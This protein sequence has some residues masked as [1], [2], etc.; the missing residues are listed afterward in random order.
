MFTQKAATFLR[1]RV[2]DRDSQSKICSPL[3]AYVSSGT[4]G[5]GNQVGG[6]SLF[7]LPEGIA[8][9]AKAAESLVWSFP[10][11]GFPSITSLHDQQNNLIP[12]LYVQY[13]GVTSC[14]L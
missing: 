6:E 9:L 14:R 4:D 10:V 2:V 7:I 11:E 3:R 12:V 8:V 5:S 1:A 13:F